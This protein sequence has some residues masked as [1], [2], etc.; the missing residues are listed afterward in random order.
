VEKNIGCFFFPG[1]FLKKKILIVVRSV[2]GEGRHLFVF[3]TRSSAVEAALVLVGGQA[4]AESDEGSEAEEEN[5]EGEVGF[6]SVEG[7]GASGDGALAADVRRERRESDDPVSEGEAG[8]EAVEDELLDTVLGDNSG[9][10]EFGDV[11]AVGDD[12][13]QQGTHE[14]VDHTVGHCLDHNLLERGIGQCDDGRVDSDDESVGDA[15][16]EEN[17]GDDANTESKEVNEQEE[18][19]GE[20]SGKEDG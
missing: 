7:F 8:G 4:V 15:A 9:E 11:E 12:A 6:I 1:F 2:V 19:N 16:E 14:E 13:D 18:T 5:P 3:E 17:E 20:F 10:V